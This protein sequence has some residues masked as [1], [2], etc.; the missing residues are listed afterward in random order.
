[1]GG[2]QKQTRPDRESWISEVSTQRL[3]GYAAMLESGGQVVRMDGTG[4]SSG[5]RAYFGDLVKTEL[6]KRG[7]Q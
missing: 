2:R 5:Q 6:Q 4:R 1:M 7:Q 3:Q